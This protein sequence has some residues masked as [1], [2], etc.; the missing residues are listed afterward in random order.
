MS[1]WINAKSNPPAY[2]DEVLVRCK[3]GAK[4]VAVRQEP[5]YDGCDRWIVR[6]PL[7]TGRRVATARITHWT[8]LPPDPQEEAHR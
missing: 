3:N 1:S 6:G 4:F 8:Q 2:D 7:G 5:T